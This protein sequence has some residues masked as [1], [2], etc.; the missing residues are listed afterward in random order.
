M[1]G[2]ISSPWLEARTNVLLLSHVPEHV[3]EMWA[4]WVS[5]GGLDL[6]LTYDTMPQLADAVF[7][8]KLASGGDNRLLLIE[9]AFF[10]DE[11]RPPSG[12]GS[13]AD[14]SWMYCISGEMLLG[15]DQA[16]TRALAYLRQPFLLTSSASR[17][18]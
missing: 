10:R 18:C 17:A 7:R 4:A 2:G 13:A 15:G 11:D 8:A 14:R 16:E 12:A 1:V 6:T 5:L 9:D 3:N